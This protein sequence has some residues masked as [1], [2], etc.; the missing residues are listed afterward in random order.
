MAEKS[1]QPR[2]LLFTRS[3]L[4]VMERWRGNPQRALELTEGL[5]EMLQSMFF[6]ASANNLNLIFSWDLT[7]LG[8]YTEALRYLEQG[9]DI[10]EKNS[11][12]YFLCR[13]YNTLG[14]TYSELYSLKNAFNFNNQALE[15][16]I[17]LKKSPAMAYIVSEMRAMTEVNLI[18]NKFEMGKADEA[19]E[20]LACFEEKIASPD[21]IFMRD[22]WG[23][24][25]KDLKG[26]LLLKRRDLDV[27]EEVVRQGLEVATKRQYKK[28]IGRAERLSGQILAERGAIDLAEAKLR[29]ALSKLEE[30][31]NP[32]QLWITHTALARLYEKMNRQ[33]L[34]R[35]HWQAAASV[36][37]STADDLEDEELRATFI[38]AKPVQEILVHTNR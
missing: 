33:D 16:I 25:M 1:G 10:A 5:P 17:A 36:V 11:L 29:D 2:A 27:A 3:Y 7:E 21:Y 20:D 22:R 9:L 30:V 35:N 23:T 31:G 38:N 32:K 13:Y 15:N 8:R 6:I 14:W 19:W 37:N 26:I 34:E 24:R 18:E 12:R 28:Y 4:A